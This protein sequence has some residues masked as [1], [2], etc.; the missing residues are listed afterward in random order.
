VER[1]GLSIAVNLATTPARMP[2][3]GR[4]LLASSPDVG[5][6]GRRLLLPPDSVAVVDLEAAEPQP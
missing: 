5:F 3:L 1:A 4:L 6:D 2:T